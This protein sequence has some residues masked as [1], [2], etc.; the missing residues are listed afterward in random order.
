MRA[1]CAFVRISL[2]ATFVAGFKREQVEREAVGGGVPADLIEGMQRQVPAKPK[3]NRPPRKARNQQLLH[4]LG[5]GAFLFGVSRCGG[6]RAL[7]PDGVR[8]TLPQRADV[9]LDVDLGLTNR[10]PSHIEPVWGMPKKWPAE[11]GAA[12]PVIQDRKSRN[13]RPEA[14]T[15]SPNM[16]GKLC[17]RARRIRSCRVDAMF[18]LTLTARGDLG[19]CLASAFE[20]G[21]PFCHRFV[22]AQDDLDIEWIKLQAAAV[23]AGLFAS[24][25]R[26]SRTEEGVDDDIST[27]GHVEQ[28]VFQHGNWLDSGVVLQSFARFGAQAGC[29]RV[30][31]EI[32]SPATV[33]AELDV[34]N[35]G[36]LSLFE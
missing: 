1:V 8:N 27:F 23:S 9:A 12:K 2:S 17:E 34:I 6:S 29:A 19:I 33:L 4:C 26:R 28:R 3:P 11:T 16:V 18:G 20:D 13:C 22:S 15:R 24:D 31:P 35:V 30:G 32:R 7:V 36:R 25:E 10:S 21:W 14:R 5:I